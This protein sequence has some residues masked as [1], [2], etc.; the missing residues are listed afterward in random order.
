MHCSIVPPLPDYP[1]VRPEESLCLRLLLFFVGK[2]YLQSEP[3]GTPLDDFAVDLNFV[4]LLKKTKA[5]NAV[6][7]KMVGVLL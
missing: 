4:V 7:L 3:T 5:Q 1:G 6:C 2:K